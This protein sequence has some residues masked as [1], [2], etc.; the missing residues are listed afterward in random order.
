MAI[1]RPKGINKNLGRRPDWLRIKL[2]SGQ[3]Y[4]DVYDEDVTS[5][6]LNF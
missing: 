2:P 4:V 5:I 1:E 3:N 6:E